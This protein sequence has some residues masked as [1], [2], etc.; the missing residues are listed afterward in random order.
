MNRILRESLMLKCKVTFPLLPT[1]SQGYIA[2]PQC[3]WN[4]L[5]GLFD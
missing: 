3:Q 1:E 2:Q 4:V 5:G